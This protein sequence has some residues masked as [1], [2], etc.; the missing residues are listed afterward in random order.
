MFQTKMENCGHP[1]INRRFLFSYLGKK[2]VGPYDILDDP[3]NIFNRMFS[4]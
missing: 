3:N 2:N 1:L 4:I